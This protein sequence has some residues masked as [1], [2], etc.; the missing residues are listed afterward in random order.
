MEREELNIRLNLIWMSNILLWRNKQFKVLIMEIK[1]LIILFMEEEQ[2]QSLIEE[3]NYMEEKDIKISITIMTI[4][5]VK[6]I[7]TRNKIKLL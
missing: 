3:N 1:I 2:G 6:M 4:L 7:K 5:E